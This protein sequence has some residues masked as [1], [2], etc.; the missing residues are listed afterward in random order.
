M[1]KVYITEQDR[2]NDRL[3][4]EI[5]TE[6]GRRDWPQYRLADKIGINRMTMYKR[7]KEPE[8]FTLREFR[9]LVRLLG[10][11]DEQIL[12]ALRQR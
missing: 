7:L 10:F 4:K 3:L 9:L 8:K 6:L 12:G 11:S 5:G 1:P 2:L